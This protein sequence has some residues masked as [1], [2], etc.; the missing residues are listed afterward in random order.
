MIFYPDLS[1]KLIENVVFALCDNSNVVRLQILDKPGK[2]QFSRDLL[3]R[4]AVSD[5]LHISFC[6]DHC[7]FHII[8]SRILTQSSQSQQQLSCGLNKMS[9]HKDL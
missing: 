5:P 3:N 6:D 8:S 1:Y 4:V 9:V 7:S 2:L